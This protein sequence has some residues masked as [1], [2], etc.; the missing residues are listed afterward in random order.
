LNFFNVDF[1][2]LVL[3]LV[4]LILPLIS[5]NMQQKPQES[6]W[7]TKPF[8]LLASTVQASFFG[9]SNGVQSTTA[10]YVNLIGIKKTNEDLSLKNSELMARLNVLAELEHE[11]NRLKNLLSFK[12]ATK[13]ELVAAQVIGRDLVPDHNT[14]T[15]NKGTSHGLKP[16]MAVLTTE[17][18]LGY[19][20]RPDFLTSRVMLITDRYSVVD[21]I[22]ARSRAQ[23]I[24]E[25]RNSTSL[26]LKYV[27]KTA[28]VNVGDLV[29]TG[30]LDNIFPKGY[31]LAKIESIERKNYLVS[32]KI[33][34]R[35]VVDPKVVEEVLVVISAKS[36][37]LT[38][39]FAQ[40]SE[41]EGGEATETENP[42]GQQG[43]PQ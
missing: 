43:I 25:G 38:P 9:F 18:A 8:S 13:M 39:Q 34:L 16:G 12:E 20:F 41:T 3:A 33:D 31:P 27:E 29:V 7:L 15:I 1:K 11:N 14:I 21:G 28:D 36:E 37:D 2:K 22:V 19:V 42:E 10:L 35:P 30:G 17:G 24:V 6:H 40:P 26:Q 23:G 4:V 32:L 5:I